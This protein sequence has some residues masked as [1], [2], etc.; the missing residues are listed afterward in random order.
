MA[1]IPYFKTMADPKPTQAGQYYL[2]EKIAQGGMAEI[3]KGLAYD[4]AGIKKTVCI[5]KIL[6]H[7]AASREFIDMLVDEAKIAVKLNHGNIAQIYDLGKAGDDYFI[8]MEYVDGQNLS[9][10][11]KKLLRL[12]KRIPLPILCAIT[13]EVASGLNYM[14]RKSDES[15]GSLNII[16]RDIS[17]QN[18]IISYSGTV[19]IIDF[20][21]AK[22]AV[23]VG[24]T[25][26]GILKGKFA[27]MSPEQARGDKIDPRSD[28][29][30]LGVIFHELL[31]GKRLFK[32][33]DNK[34][35]LKNVR[36][37]KVIPP[38]ELNP[39]LPKAIDEIALKALVK[40]RRHRYAFASDFHDDL[41]KF[42]H[43]HYPDF[44]P[45]QVAEFVRNLFREE[46]AI[47]KILVDEGATP[48]LI[49]DKTKTNQEEDAG[50]STS[51]G[52][53][54]IDWREFMLEADW[55][56][57]IE[58]RE[59]EEKSPEES[60]SSVSG[61]ETQK[62]WFRELSFR[63][64]I[65][66]WSSGFLIIFAAGLATF[67]GWKYFRNLEPRTSNLEPRTEPLSTIQS[68]KLSTVIIESSPPG[69]SIYIDDQ[70]TGLTTPTKLENLE[71]KT[72][73]TLGLYLT[74]Y[75]FFKTAFETNAGETQNFHIE[76][77]LDY[78]SLKVISQPSG[79]KVLMNG[80]TI[81]VTPLIKEEMKPGSIVKIEL[82]LEEFET[83]SKELQITAGKEQIIQVNLQRR[84]SL[85]KAS[86]PSIIE[87]D[88]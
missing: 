55:P 61:E 34:E 72:K 76:L 59:E 65:L 63:K 19:K 42:L 73:N 52:Q 77:T 4:L 28:I 87:K 53:P 5:K 25:E 16:H 2:L 58:A 8:V 83:Y 37:A 46:L 38:S 40:D 68:P 81:G 17:P 12:G 1:L 48:H 44:Q 85:P 75:K 24:H 84:T 62:K 66:F 30:S 60:E 80:E 11:N 3:Y 6:P 70:E 56:E 79:A 47:S 29:F 67:F 26:S 13:A 36:R 14:H 9:R 64:Q 21:I 7:I 39:D 74:N 57:E 49:L 69:A 15:G 41:S 27:Y 31:T 86:P 10:I 23:K 22:A 82:A 20:G 35:T 18:I 33:S 45:S 78:G 43:T 54:G 50:E 32:S 51:G 71:I 88:D